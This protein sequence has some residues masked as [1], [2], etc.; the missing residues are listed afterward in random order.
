MIDGVGI[1]HDIRDQPLRSNH[2]HVTFSKAVQRRRMQASAANPTREA[3]LNG[4]NGMFLLVHHVVGFLFLCSCTYGLAASTLYP[5]HSNHW[6][7]RRPL[8]L[9]LFVVVVV[10]SL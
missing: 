4:M 9:L 7:K 8:S 3:S 6:I 2:I 1:N 10:S 5:M